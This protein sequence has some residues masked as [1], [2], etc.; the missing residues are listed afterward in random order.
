MHQQISGA[1]DAAKPEPEK[2]PDTGKSM[3]PTR[4]AAGRADAMRRLLGGEL[5]KE[6]ED[7]LNAGQRSDSPAEF[8]TVMAEIKRDN[9]IRAYYYDMFQ[10]SRDNLDES[11][12]IRSNA[13]VAH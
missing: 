13:P 8:L 9:G 2:Q 12:Q 6:A 10:M 5:S 11:L 7:K 4:N 1:V 3:D